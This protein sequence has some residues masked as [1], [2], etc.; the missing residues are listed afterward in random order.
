MAVIEVK[1]AEEFKDL[2]KKH[3]K[4]AVDF[5]AEW[6]GPCKIISPVFKQLSEQHSDITFLSV[7]VD[8]LEAV[9]QEYG[10]RAMPTFIMFKD[11]EKS[12]E[13][14]GANKSGLEEKIQ[15]LAA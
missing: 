8:K 14:T 3:P 15:A 1:T 12:N 6:C 4:V 7:D 5:Y 10:I 11:G 13:L 9:A 2:L